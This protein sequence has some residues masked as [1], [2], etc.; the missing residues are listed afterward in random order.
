MKMERSFEI[1]TSSLHYIISVGN[2]QQTT[3]TKPAVL[4]FVVGMAV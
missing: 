3:V 4:H 1:E 2:Y